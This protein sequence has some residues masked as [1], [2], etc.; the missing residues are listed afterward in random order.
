M[1]LLVGGWVAV[2]LPLPNEKATG[3]GAGENKDDDGAAML[4]VDVLEGKS[5]VARVD[6][7]RT[8]SLA[9]SFSFFNA[10]YV[11][12]NRC[13]GKERSSRTGT[14]AINFLISSRSFS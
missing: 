6:V 4:V 5:S 1:L 12:M 14:A 13:T 9:S 2:V 11:A 7:A 8:F 10:Q 3:A